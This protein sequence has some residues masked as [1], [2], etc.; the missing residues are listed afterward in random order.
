MDEEETPE[1]FAWLVANRDQ[2]RES[3]PP[4]GA[5]IGPLAGEE[6]VQFLKMLRKE[7]EGETGGGE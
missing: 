3:G 6:A 1:Y 5:V 4:M 7:A 2:I